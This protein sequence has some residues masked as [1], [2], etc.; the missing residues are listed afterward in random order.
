MLDWLEEPLELLVKEQVEFQVKSQEKKR[1]YWKIYMNLSVKM[2]TE[3]V[4]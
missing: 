1:V 2:T 3:E 4:H